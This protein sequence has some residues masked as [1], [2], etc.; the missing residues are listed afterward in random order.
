MLI[1][2][3]IKYRIY[4]TKSQEKLLLNNLEGCRLIYNQMIK[5]RID[6]WE[7][8]KKSNSCFGQ[9]KHFKNF[10][11]KDKYDIYA[12][13]KQNVAVRVDLAFKAFFRRLK[14]GE[15]PGFPRFKGE[16]RYDSFTYPQTGWKI[17]DNNIK[18]TKIGNIKAVIH[19]KV[20]CDVKTCTVKKEGDS[21]YV[22]FSIETEPKQYE[23]E[24]KEPIGIDVGLLSFAIMSDETLIDNPRFFKKEEK[25][26]S[27][28]Q[29]KK[30]KEERGSK[31]YNKLSKVIQKR[32][33]KIKNRRKDFCHKLSK[34][35]VDKYNIICIENLSINE[36]KEEKR[37]LSKSIHDASWRLF[38]DLLSYKAAE[39]GRKLVK[40]NPAYTSQDC[41]RC[42]Y[43][44]KKRLSDRIHN[45]PDCKL[46][47]DR[48]LNASRNILRIG[49]YSL[50]KS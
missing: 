39:A 11:N 42:G 34:R 37:Y 33:K 13:V 28:L 48:D 45:C 23:S 24:T 3:A 9:Q 30:S 40:V 19:K 1:K 43:R 35:I 29:Q 47:I 44:V 18:L 46:I 26:I 4:P 38:M 16:T 2:K 17:L 10:L 50:E 49:L 32:H 31:K 6:D 36:M 22:I 41:S 21:W 25:N 8:E 5:Q 20:K 27:K 14:N 7:N 12:Q 15:N